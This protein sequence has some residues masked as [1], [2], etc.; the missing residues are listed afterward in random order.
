[1]QEMLRK[2]IHHLQMQLRRILSAD[3]RHELAVMGRT[4]VADVVDGG[5]FIRGGYYTYFI[6]DDRG[7]LIKGGRIFY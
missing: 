2:L 4:C 6:I 7:L 5:L 1:M 3:E